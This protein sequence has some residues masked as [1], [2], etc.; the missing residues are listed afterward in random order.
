MFRKRCKIGGKLLL[1]T[2]RK[3]YVSFWLV[4]KSVTLNDLERRNGRYF[5]LGLFQRIRV[6]SGAHSVKV[7]VRYLI[8][9]WVLVNRGNR[10][11]YYFKSRVNS[12]LTHIV[13]YKD[14]LSWAVRKGL[15]W[16]RCS[17]E[18]WVGWVQGTC[19]TW[20]C[21]CPHGKR[22]FWGVWLIEKHCK[23]GFGV[24]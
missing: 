21:K 11:D 22:H 18:F 9:W 23:A 7:H 20:R 10:S 17:L 8:S 3:S 16:S 6:A 12:V 24:G 4:P 19:I 5:A 1:I 13:K 2:N 15:N 14:S